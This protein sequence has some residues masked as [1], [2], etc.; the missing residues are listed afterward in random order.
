MG[1]HCGGIGMVW[2]APGEAHLFWG[3]P[4]GVFARRPVRL[5]TAIAAAVPQPIG[6]APL[7]GGSLELLH[8]VLLAHPARLA[9][10]P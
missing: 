8:L 3:C 7:V 1:T 5:S 10:Y 6:R 4:R 9:D 2:I